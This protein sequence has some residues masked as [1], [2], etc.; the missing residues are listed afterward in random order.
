MHKQRFTG[1]GWAAVAMLLVV[2]ASTALFGSLT[3]GAELKRWV[4]SERRKNANQ[5]GAAGNGDA[6]AVSRT[7]RTHSRRA[8]STRDSEDL[9][10]KSGD[11]PRPRSPLKKNERPASVWRRILIAQTWWQA[12]RTRSCVVLQLVSQVFRVGGIVF[13]FGIRIRHQRMPRKR[14]DGK[15][16]RRVE[17]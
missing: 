8:T 9:S 10:R 16:V 2:A 13:S 11:R 4:K 14:F 3:A 1:M 6:A 5:S 15:G 17:I 7:E 12:F